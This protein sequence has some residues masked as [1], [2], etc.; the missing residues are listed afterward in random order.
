MFKRLGLFLAFAAVLCS[1]GDK[2]Q[3]IERVHLN[4]DRERWADKTL[5]KLSLEEKIGQI[6]TIRAYAEFLNVD[7]P[8]YRQ[9]RDQIRKHHIGSVALF[10]RIDGPYRLKTQP[11][12]VAMLTNLLQGESKLPLLFAADFERGPSMRMAGVPE[13][14]DAMAFGATARPELV[15]QFARATAR[16][17]RAMG[18]HWNYFP[19]ADVNSNP[20]NPIINTRSYGEDPQMVAEMT[21]AYIRGSREGGMIST[22][23]HFPGHGDT[24]TDSHIEAA[25][26]FGDR[27]RLDSVELPPFRKAVDSG[28]DSV[29][30]AHVTVPSLEPDPK[31]VATISHNVIT[32]L[33]REQMKFDGLIV[34]DAMDMRAVTSLFAHEPKPQAAAR[35]AIEA[36]KA[37]NDMVLLP[38]HVEGAYN[39]LIQAVRSGEIPEETINSAV[40]RVLRAKASV[41]LHKARLVDVQQVARDVT[42]PEDL[43]LAQQIADSA[44][45]LVRDNGKVL[46]LAKD[47][48]APR[49]LAYGE[50][51][52]QGNRVL[53]V[54]LSDDVRSPA[55]RRFE[56]EVRARVPGAR[57]M[58]A[59]SRFAAGIMPQVVEA[60]RTASAVLVAAYV[61]PVSGKMQNVQGK[62]TNTV[63]L[64]DATGELLRQVLA[65]AGEKTV[66]T[67]VGN[68]YLASS[69]PEVQTYLCTFSGAPTSEAAAVRAIFGE[70]EIQGRTP[71]TLPEV[72]ARGAGLSRPARTAQK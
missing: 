56:R 24:G 47:G 59:D 62:M 11:Y 2:F 34:T 60:A 20:A 54:I 28:V 29:M 17:S 21:A 1:A 64:A 43:A 32:K 15:E 10:A 61:V 26:V 66:V 65:V 52:Q 53:V 71:V 16:Q 35:A 38:E 7:G 42:R 14:P 9:L 51:E 72:A 3:K 67:A 36:V 8:D 4:S 31:R 27:Q 33:L 68:P 57:V 30:V 48:T 58:F 46:P 40:R 22:A 70:N 50:V 12:E 13:F 44:V 6:L 18:I 19:V 41:G 55:G 63:S 5:K 25:S 69:F 45:T 37:G 23:K 49:P 39:G